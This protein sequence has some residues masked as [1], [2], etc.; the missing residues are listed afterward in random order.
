MVG[1]PIFLAAVSSLFILDKAYVL[2]IMYVKDVITLTSERYQNATD[3]RTHFSQTLDHAVYHRPQF[4]R[5]THNRVVM[6]GTD[7]LSS[8]LPYAVFHLRFIPEEDGSVIAVCDEI[9]DVIG[10]GGTEAEAEHSFIE[11]MQE[12]AEEYYREYELYSRAPNRK[13]HLPYILR[14]LAADSADEIRRTMLCP[15]GR[16]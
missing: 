5:R 3:V 10:T 9:E 4:I 8:V 2:F 16:N 1:H 13:A 15:A 12:Y 14:V 7:M 6:L 11:A